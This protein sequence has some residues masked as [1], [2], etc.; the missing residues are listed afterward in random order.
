MV[1]AIILTSG[2]NHHIRVIYLEKNR[3]SNIF[4][5]F[6]LLNSSRPNGPRCP[7]PNFSFPSMINI[8]KYIKITAKL[9]HRTGM[10]YKYLIN[11]LYIII[12]NIHMYKK[13]LK[14]YS[15]PPGGPWLIK[16]FNKR[17]PR[18][19]SGGPRRGW[20]IN[21]FK[22]NGPWG[23]PGGVNKI[24]KQLIYDFLCNFNNL[25]K[26]DKRRK[27]RNSVFIS[28]RTLKK[29][30]G[31]RINKVYSPPPGEGANKPSRPMAGTVYSNSLNISLFGFFETIESDHISS[32]SILG[33][34]DYYLLSNIFIGLLL[35]LVNTYF[36]LSVKYLDKGGGFECGFSSF[37]QTRE[38]FNVIFYRVSLLFL[39]FDLEIILI[40]PFTAL[41]LKDQSNAKNNILAFLYI[42]VIGFIYELKEGA[43]NIV[44]TIHST[45]IN[46]N[47]LLILEPD[48]LN[49]NFD[50]TKNYGESNLF[51]ELV[52]F[53]HKQTLSSTPPD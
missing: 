47:D 8:Y 10:N 24:N 30:K 6:F 15:P 43:L 22:I 21:L 16:Y 3:K 9:R 31:I 26:K 38:R 48:S 42:L 44:K 36:S 49:S 14:L 40:F 29:S 35:F 4:S 5:L 19:A 20:T 25:N 12:N 52:H 46:V 50:Q 7:C 41:Y 17:P 27:V 34:L 53:Y 51:L 28:N 13:L 2:D 37:I 32:E 39:I 23:A 33:N 1:G 45:E 18:G 11:F